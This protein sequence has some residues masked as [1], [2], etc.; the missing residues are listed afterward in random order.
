MNANVRPN[1]G[2]GHP[3]QSHKPPSTKNLF[4]AISRGRKCGFGEGVKLTWLS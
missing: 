3:P 2:I 4:P 1:Y